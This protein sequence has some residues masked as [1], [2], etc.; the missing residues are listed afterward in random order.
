MSYVD[1]VIESVVAKNPAE[2]EF[3]QAV[4]EVLESLRPVIEAN[5][6]KYRKVAGFSDFFQ[7]ISKIKSMICKSKSRR[8]SNRLLRFFFS[9]FFLMMIPAFRKWRPVWQGRLP[10]E[11]QRYLKKYCVVFLFWIFPSFSWRP[12]FGDGQP[13]RGFSR[14]MP[15]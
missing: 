10:P 2:P 12:P 15:T 4:K 8:I 9:F 3:H 14:L 6:E 1:E 7:N 13:F 11:I 5:E